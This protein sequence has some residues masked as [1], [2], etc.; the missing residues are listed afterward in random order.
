M[1]TL[2]TLLLLLASVNT[3]AQNKQ[4]ECMAHAVYHEARGESATGQ[5][6]VA[7]VVLNRVGKPGFPNTICGVVYQPQQFTNIRQTKPDKRSASWTYAIA[8]SAYAI[9]GISQDPT[10][11]AKYFYAQ[12]VVQPHWRKGKKLTVIGNHTFL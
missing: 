7:H 10:H 8:T 12:K 4:V 2:M 9:A 6:A 3:H 5:A 1:K 11:G